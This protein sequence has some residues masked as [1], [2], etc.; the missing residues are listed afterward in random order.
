MS[1]RLG[2]RSFPVVAGAIVVLGCA[3]MPA[4]AQQTPPAAA[5]AQRPGP[6]VGSMAPDFELPAA[7]RYGRLAQPFRL[8][9]QRGQTVVLAFFTQA[10]TRG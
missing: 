7:T 8:S 5:P 2:R 6:E 4:P 9:Q 1:L 3:P 10:R